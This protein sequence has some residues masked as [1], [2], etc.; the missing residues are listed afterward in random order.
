MD[1]TNL[2]RLSYF[3]FVFPVI[4]VGSFFVCLDEEHFWKSLD[5]EPVQQ[6]F[7][8]VAHDAE[9]HFFLELW[10]LFLPQTRR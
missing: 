2:I 5:V 10:R 8:S 7:L 4:I 3:E 9:S 1:C 6:G